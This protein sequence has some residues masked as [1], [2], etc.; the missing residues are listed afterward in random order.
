M[1]DKAVFV[2][3]VIKG[4]SSHSIIVQ[5]VHRGKFPPCVRVLL[6]SLSGWPHGVS[7]LTW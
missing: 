1:R 5:R 4:T 2:I 7:E 6:C 3:T